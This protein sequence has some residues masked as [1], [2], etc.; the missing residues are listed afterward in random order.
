MLILI[1]LDE[2][3]PKDNIEISAVTETTDTNL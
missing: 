1:K 2:F 3:R